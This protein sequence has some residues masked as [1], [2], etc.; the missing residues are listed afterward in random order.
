MFQALGESYRDLKN[1]KECFLRQETKEEHARRNKTNIKKGTYDS[2]RASRKSFI[3]ISIL[4]I[5]VG[6]LLSLIPGII[7]YAAISAYD[8]SNDMSGPV[9]AIF[10]CVGIIVIIMKS[11]LVK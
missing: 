9:T 2:Y 3:F 10:S 4:E 5:G 11:L 7:I 1:D 8:S 6:L